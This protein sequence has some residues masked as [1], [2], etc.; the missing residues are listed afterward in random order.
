MRTLAL[1]LAMEGNKGCISRS[2]APVLRCVLSEM[3][4]Q[5]SGYHLRSYVQFEIDESEV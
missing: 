1:I 4:Q 2:P 3:I 5:E